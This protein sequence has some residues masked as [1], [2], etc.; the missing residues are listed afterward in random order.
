MRS[1]R[2]RVVESQISPKKRNRGRSP[3]GSPYRSQSPPFRSRRS[4]SRERDS[5]VN[6]VESRRQRDDLSSQRMRGKRSPPRHAVEREDEHPGLGCRTSDSLSHQPSISLRSPQRD[7]RSQSDTRKRVPVMS[8]SPSS[9]SQSGS[10]LQKQRMASPSV[11][12]IREPRKRATRHDS[13][14]EETRHAREVASYR[15]NS[16]Q[17]RIGHSPP[18]DSRKKSTANDTDLEQDAPGRIAVNQSDHTQPRSTDQVPRSDNSS[19]R[20]DLPERRTHQASLVSEEIE[21]GPGRLEGEGFRP[22]SEHPSARKLGR[23]SSPDEM[24]TNEKVHLKTTYSREDYRTVEKKQPLSSDVEY[25]EHD[26]KTDNMQKPMKKVDRSKQLSLDSD[27]DGNRTRRS[28]PMEKRKSRRTEG[29]E[30]SVDDD[31]GYDSE[32][33]ERKEAKRRRKE[34]KKLRKEE[35]RRRREERH[36]RREERRA[37]KLN[38]KSVDTVT[39]PSDLEMKQNDAGDSDGDAAVKR[40]SHRSDTEAAELE[41]KKLEMELRNKALESLR[42]KKAISR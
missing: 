15:A 23:Y 34:E 22:Y 40:D 17:K 36:R 38:A 1:P 26:K 41:Q 11:S 9:S 29:R 19:R 6:G 4:L 7:P 20:V 35:R 42:A 5:R 39:P 31:A 14:E 3:Y 18:S 33:D 8:P 25:S 2:R 21:Y 30:T 10:P 12:P 37:G 28:R 24:L 27:S 13:P 16:S 32:K